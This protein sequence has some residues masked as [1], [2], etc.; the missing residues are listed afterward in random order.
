MSTVW[1]VEIISDKET[2]DNKSNVAQRIAVKYEVLSYSLNNHN[3]Y[4]PF[5]KS[6]DFSVVPHNKTT[7]EAAVQWQLLQ[8]ESKCKRQ[9]LCS[10]LQVPHTIVPDMT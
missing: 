1:T 9:S 7:F 10:Y 5:E 8:T 2:A 4:F 6:Y 3:I